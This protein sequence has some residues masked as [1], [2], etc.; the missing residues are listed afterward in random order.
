MAATAKTSQ[1]SE[2]AARQV[3]AD[4]LDLGV[5]QPSPCLLP[6]DK[7]AA[8]AAAR[9]DPATQSPLLLQ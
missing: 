5:G 2:L 3:A 1:V 8:A 4:V 6:L 9:L 7:I